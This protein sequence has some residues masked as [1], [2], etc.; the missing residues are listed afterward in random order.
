[1]MKIRHLEIFIS[2][3]V[4]LPLMLVTTEMHASNAAVI[5]GGTITVESSVEA[6][7]GTNVTIN[8]GKLD[9]SASD[10]GINAS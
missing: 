8:G 6:L 4:R 9:L 5:D 1:M 10:D 3:P 7:E 2:S